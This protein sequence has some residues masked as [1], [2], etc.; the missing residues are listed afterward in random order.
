MLSLGHQNGWFEKN[1]L[2]TPD[3]PW[4]HLIGYVLVGLLESCMLDS[5]NCN[6]A[7]L[8]PLLAAAAKNIANY[9]LKSKELSA[10]GQLNTLPGSFDQNWM[11]DDNWTCV[12]GNAQ[13]AFFLRKMSAIFNDDSLII[14]ADHLIKELKSIQYVDGVSDPDLYGGLPGSYP[15]GGGYA[16]NAIPNWGVKFFADTLLQKVVPLS[17]QKYLG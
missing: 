9:C 16:S 8:L 7:K 6:P 2:S 4:T 13:I 15:L 1:S 5:H 17:G 14:A 3:K 12:T 11:S 10:N